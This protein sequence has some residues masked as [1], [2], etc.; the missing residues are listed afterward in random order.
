MT[1]ERDPVL[2]RAIDTLREMPDVDRATIDRVVAAAASARMT[3]VDDVPL[4]APPPRRGVRAWIVGVV[5]AAA[6]FAGFMLRGAIATSSSDDVGVRGASPQRLQAVRSTAEQKSLP[7]M[8]QFVFNSRNAHRVSVV[9]DFNGWN[10]ANAPMAQSPDGEWST[11]I[12][13]LPGRH[14]FGF[15]IDDSI[16]MLDPRAPKARD[17]DLGT[18]GSVVIVGR[19]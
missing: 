15:M 16:F 9:G 11:T 14:I 8:Q 3:P 12:P 13:V 17:P 5:A 4:L 7:I 18:D 10:P 6:V 19:P 2:G 1:D